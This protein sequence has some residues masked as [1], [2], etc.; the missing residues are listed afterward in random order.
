MRNFHRMKEEAEDV[1]ML[2]SS[3][4]PGKMI[5]WTTLSV[6]L[7]IMLVLGFGI[8]YGTRPGTDTNS[9]PAYYFVSQHNESCPPLI[10]ERLL[11]TLREG[12]SFEG[13][14]VKLQCRGNYVPYPSSVRSDIILEKSLI[15][16]LQS[17]VHDDTSC[18]ITF[19][20]NRSVL[21]VTPVQVP[22]EVCVQR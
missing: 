20:E 19:E 15:F 18:Y 21:S 16:H 10:G 11:T 1:L 14:S 2:V 9:V 8:G 17:D 4:L 7:L 3:K 13:L 12:D 22:A 5:I 6:V